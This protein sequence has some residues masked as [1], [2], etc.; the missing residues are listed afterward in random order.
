MITPCAAKIVGVDL[1]SKKQKAPEMDDPIKVQIEVSLPPDT[2]LK[3][4]GSIMLNSY[5]EFV[6]NPAEVYVPSDATLSSQATWTE[7]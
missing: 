1:P 7:Q 5:I 4:P 6:P 3:H 2:Q